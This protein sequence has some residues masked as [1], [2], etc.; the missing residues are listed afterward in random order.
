[1]YNRISVKPL[2]IIGISFV[3]LAALV[4]FFASARVTSFEQCV[5]AGNPVME[6]YPRQCMA[7][8]RTFTE[9]IGGG[10]G[11]NG[12][13]GVSGYDTM[14]SSDGSIFEAPYPGSVNGGGSSGYFG[15]VGGTRG[16]AEYPGN[17]FW[18]TPYPGPYTNYPGIEYPSPRTG[19]CT[20]DAMQCP[21]GSWV[22]RS[23]PSCQFVCPAPRP[24]GPS[25]IVSSD[26]FWGRGVSPYYPSYVD[27]GSHGVMERPFAPYL[28]PAPEEENPFSWF[29]NIFFWFR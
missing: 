20:E 28:S 24:V 11:S 22:G 13:R 5:A 3:A 17:I 4:P 15:S 23:G 21:D 9:N 10:S 7:N 25:T 1:M 29:T 6:S 27:D 2:Q 19:V 14:V 8:G 12:N 26:D 16:V 18:E